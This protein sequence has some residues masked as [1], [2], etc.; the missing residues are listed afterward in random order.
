MKS[1]LRF[2]LG[3]LQGKDAALEPYK[4]L[5]QKIKLASMRGTAAAS[6]QERRNLVCNYLFS[7]YDQG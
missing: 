6:H 4:Q 5:K 1:F 3:S 2:A 7:A